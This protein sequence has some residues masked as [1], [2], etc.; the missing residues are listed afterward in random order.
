MDEAIED[1]VGECRVSAN[2]LRRSWSPGPRFFGQK[3]STLRNAMST[4]NTR[5]SR[6]TGQVYFLSMACRMT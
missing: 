5:S 4:E 6:D 2:G 3:R 1:G